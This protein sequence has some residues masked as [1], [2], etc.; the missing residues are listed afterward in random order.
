[1]EVLFVGLYVHMCMY[2][3]MYAS[4][5]VCIYEYNILICTYMYMICMIVRSCSNAVRSGVYQLSQL[6]YT[7]SI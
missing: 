2:L 4:I 1:M 7:C 6:L 5:Y 3:R